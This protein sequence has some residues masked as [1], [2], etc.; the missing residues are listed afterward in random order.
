[1]YTHSRFRTF[2]HSGTWYSVIVALPDDDVAS[3]Y[4]LEGQLS[5]LGSLAVFNQNPHFVQDICLKAVLG[6]ASDLPQ[7][8]MESVAKVWLEPISGEAPKHH[9]HVCPE[10]VYFPS[11]LLLPLKC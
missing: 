4:N 6:D 8:I 1:M 5:K 9:I 11:I 10:V 7:K 2:P 3:V